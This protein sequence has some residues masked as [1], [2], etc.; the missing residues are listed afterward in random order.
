MSLTFLGWCERL[1]PL[2]GQLS[3]D[4]LEPCRVVRVDRGAV[5]V[6]TATG[7][8]PARVARQLDPAGETGPAAVGDWAALQRSPG[9]ALVRGLMPRTTALTRRAAG[10]EREAQVLAA[11]VDLVLVVE[12]LDRGPNPRRIE[13]ATALA[14]DAGATPLVVL[15]KTDLADDLSAAVAT[16]SQAAPFI[17]VVPVSAE[18]GSGLEVLASA[19][20]DGTTAVL[21]GAS[22][23]GKSTLANA[24]LGGVRLATGAVRRVDRR[25]RHTTTRRELIPLPSGGCLI[26]TPGV[27]ELGLWLGADGIGAAFPEIAELAGGC[28]Y[29]DCRHDGEPGCAVAVAVAEGRLAAA[30]LASYHRLRRE[31]ERLER[32]AG[33]RGLA[34]QRAHERVFARLC[35][36]ETRRKRKA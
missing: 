5:I 33:P 10:G 34:E 31:A 11:N 35:R 20:S 29:R 18:S 3:I 15:T 7:D 2:Y 25:G 4:G 24:L 22:G 16:A 19:L 28:R 8:V 32:A 26:D 17:D 27:R 6:G 30:R 1:T 21:L 12:P 36:A 13:R 23:A 14:W 9:T